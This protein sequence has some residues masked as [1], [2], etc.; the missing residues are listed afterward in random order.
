MRGLS[1]LNILHRILKAFFLLNKIFF[2][3]QTMGLFDRLFG[4]TIEK[5][6]PNVKFGRFSDAY[7]TDA[8]YEAWHRSL[9]KFDDGNHFDAYEDFFDYLAAPEGGN[10]AYQRLGDTHFNFELFQGSKAVKGYSDGRRFRAEAKVVRADHSNVG[11]MRRLIEKNFSLRYSRFALD[12]NGDVVIIFDTYLLDGSPHKLYHAMNELAT[13]A[14]KMDDLL[15][16]EF[17]M[18]HPLGTDHT[19]ELPQAL[20]EAKYDFTIKTVKAV[21]NDMEHG[22]PD[23]TL[24]PQATGYQLLDLIYKL[25]YLVRPE[26]YMMETFERINRT[27]FKQDERSVFEKNLRFYKE[28]ETLIARPKE[29]FFKEIYTTTS[30]FGMTQVVD[31]ARLS[32]FID[33]VIKECDWYTKNKHEN[34]VLAITGYIVGY[35]LFYWAVPRPDKELLHLYYEIIEAD[36]FRSLGFP[37]EYFHE[38]GKFNRSAIKVEVNKIIK[39]NRRKFPTLSIDTTLLVYGSTAEFAKSFLQM[40]KEMEI[41]EP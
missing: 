39:S 40:I 17:S 19:E 15:V 28:L 38:N 6:R 41:E 26:G 12:Q 9:E 2:A 20:K 34:I 11:F 3:N 18:L 31:H 4:R 32:A 23:A 16:D 13:T 29:E 14:D 35:S 25:D 37:I 30:T 1:S 36:Y 10:V 7:K 24:Y 5:S 21:I 22:Q 27:Y 8:Q 33:E